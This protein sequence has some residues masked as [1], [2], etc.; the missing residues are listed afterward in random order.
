[1]LWHA[2]C[3]L[4]PMTLSRILCFVFF[5]LPVFFFKER[6]TYPFTRRSSISQFLLLALSV[7]HC[8]C[9]ECIAC[10]YVMTRDYTAV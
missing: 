10:V 1:M 2:F 5:N 8:I 4:S 3:A 7:S 9:T 6:N